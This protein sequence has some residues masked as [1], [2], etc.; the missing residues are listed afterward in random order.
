LR[1]TDFNEKYFRTH[2][3]RK[4]QGQDQMRFFLDLQ[5]PAAS[6]IW[7][8]QDVKE[9]DLVAESLYDPAS[10]FGLAEDRKPVPIAAALVG[11]VGYRFVEKNRPPVV[12][13]IRPYW[14][15]K[16]LVAR[17]LTGELTWDAKQGFVRIDTPRT[18]AV[19]GFLSSGPHMLNSAIINS[20]TRF[21]AV[22]VTAM[23]GLASIRAARHLLITAVG[24]ARN[25]SMEYETTTQ[26]SR[27]GRPL[28]HLK[29]EGTAPALLEAVTGEIQIQCDRPKDF[30]AWAL[31]PVGQRLREIPLQVQD[32]ALQLKLN[33][34]YETVYYELSAP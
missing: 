24:P 33:A 14:D 8:R 9:A 3:E 15:A 7:L 2:P 10:V 4:V 6:V 26:P 11:K 13:D 12:K 25:T 20:F 32:H 5:F 18:Q 21:G 34:E 28:W 31:D 16:N 30:K 17:S 27:L 22:Y 19:I 29:A 23:D 1:N